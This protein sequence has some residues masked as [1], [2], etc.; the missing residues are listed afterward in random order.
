MGKIKQKLVRRTAANLLKR[1]MEFTEHFDDNK[2]LLGS[3]T[4]PGKKIRNQIAGLLA[5]LKK[6]ERIAEQK[7]SE[8]IKTKQTGF[9]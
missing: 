6:S 7:F 8:S 2:K 1:G 9:K 5:K 3:N 4:M